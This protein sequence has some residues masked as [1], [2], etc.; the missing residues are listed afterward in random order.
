[1]RGFL[2]TLLGT[3]AF[4]AETIALLVPV[5]GRRPPLIAGGTATLPALIQG[6]Q[7]A[8]K[9]VAPQRYWVDEAVGH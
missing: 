7:R 4:E 9:P 1:M 6:R 2:C 3:V 8:D 5:F